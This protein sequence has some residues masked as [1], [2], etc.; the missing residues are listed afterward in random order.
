MD[1]VMTA[2]KPNA[3][4]SSGVAENW[5]RLNPVEGPVD[6]INMA[7]VTA[8]ICQGGLVMLYIGWTPEGKT[9]WLTFRG[10]NA[11]HVMRWLARRELISM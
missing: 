1:D 4:E 7:Q 6:G 11:R 10:E 8:F 3:S 2:I 5:I 9:P